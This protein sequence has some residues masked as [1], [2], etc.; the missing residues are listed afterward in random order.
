VA[1]PRGG[2]GR[3]ERAWRCW[4]GFQ[5]ERQAAASNRTT[6]PPPSCADGRGHGKQLAGVV[7]A[8]PSRTASDANA[9]GAAGYSTASGRHSGTTLTDAVTGAVPR[10]RNGILNP[11]F[12]EWLAGLP[13]GWTDCECSV[14]ASPLRK[15]RSRGTC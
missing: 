10:E 1:D 11:L 3:C 8:L 2:R 9:S 13:I 7:S 5:Q 15:R 6:R 12:V 4:R 14:I